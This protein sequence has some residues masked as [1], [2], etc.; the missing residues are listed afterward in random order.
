M[1]IFKR[2]EYIKELEETIRKQK[3]EI[4]RLEFRLDATE[5][6]LY[7]VR[8]QKIKKEE[9]ILNK[10]NYGIL[11]KDYYKVDFWNYGRFE[12]G[13]KSLSFKCEGGRNLPELIIEK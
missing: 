13:V 10:Y 2:K 4:G 12:E 6:E 8:K 5:A 7:K 1:R 3:E 9:D 11:V